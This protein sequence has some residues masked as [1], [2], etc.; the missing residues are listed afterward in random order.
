M[1]VVCGGDQKD[2]AGQ[3]ACWCSSVCGSGIGDVDDCY[4]DVATIS[5]TMRRI[6]RGKKTAASKR[7]G[8][9]ES[10]E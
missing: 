6:I 8:Q 5:M 10:L 1:T 4:D 3:Y 7:R 9:I 2:D